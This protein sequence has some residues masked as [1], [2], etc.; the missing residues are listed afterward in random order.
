MTFT[1]SVLAM[2]LALTICS[3]MNWRSGG[4]LRFEML[5]ERGAKVG[6]CATD[7]RE[8]SIVLFADGYHLGVGVGVDRDAAATIETEAR[9]VG[10][11]AIEIRDSRTSE[12]LVRS[13]LSTP[14]PEQILFEQIA[15][16]AGEGDSGTV[17]AR[18]SRMA[19]AAKH[20]EW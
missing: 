1:R 8:V 15:P 13:R 14:V 19:A 20:V 9:R 2:I 18:L 11:T 12:V 4:R 10:A 3:C 7:V 5:D 6:E 16:D 17:A